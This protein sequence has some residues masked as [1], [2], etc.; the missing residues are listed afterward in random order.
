MVRC[1]PRLQIKLKK[2]SDPRRKITQLD[3]A[4]LKS[5]PAIAAT[6]RGLVKIKLLNLITLVSASESSEV[7]PRKKEP[8]PGWFQDH[9]DT[10]NPL[11]DIRNKAMSEVNFAPRRTCYTTVKLRATRKKLSKAVQRMNG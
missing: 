3:F 11:I 9:A 5:D 7:L 8:Q 1:T 6:L 2:R 4:K 10:L